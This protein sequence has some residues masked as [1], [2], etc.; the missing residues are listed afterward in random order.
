MNTPAPDNRSQRRN[1]LML[2]AIFGLFLGSMLVAGALRFAGWQP[3]GS[4]VHG[5]LLKPPMD[6]RERAP[7]LFEG[8]TYA[9]N[10]AARTWRIVVAPPA[11]CGEACDKLA[12]DL[13][14]VWRMMGRNADHIEI[15]WLCADAACAVPS[16]LDADRSLRRMRNDA[17]WRAALPRA[18]PDLPVYVV[19]PNG[20][21]ILRY[22]PGTDLA[23]LRAD[24]AKLLKLI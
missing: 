18:T 10:P 17:A 22:P 11:D 8:G 19:D 14:K 6:L 3:S 5:E 13:D 20:F 7:T 4:N 21:L 15:L 23:G 1:R 2:L 12:N 24:L 16:P 9:W